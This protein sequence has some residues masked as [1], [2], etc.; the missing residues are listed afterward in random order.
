[1]SKT[2][3]TNSSE[4]PSN[5]NKESELSVSAQKEDVFHP[6]IKALHAALEGLCS[7]EPTLNGLELS[8]VRALIDYVAYT[9]KFN[10]VVIRSLVEDYFRTDDIQKIRRND[11][12]KAVAYLVDL[13]PRMAM[14]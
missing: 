9:H 5:D 4:G 13:D 8:S 7:D 12:D 1:M 11:F 6:A 2:H 10:E 14:N 3:N